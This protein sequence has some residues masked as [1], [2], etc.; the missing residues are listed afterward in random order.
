MRHINLLPWREERRRDQQKRFTRQT[1]LILGLC[2]MV[3]VVAMMQ[4]QAGIGVQKERNDYLQSQIRELEGRIGEVKALRDQRKLM[5]ERM[6][7]VLKLQDNRT[8]A[9]RIFDALARA[10]P[11]GVI[12]EKMELM[13]ENLELSGTALNNAE[14]SSFMR[15]LDQSEVFHAA[16]LDVIKVASGESRRSS[17][18]LKVQTGKAETGS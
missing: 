9:V 13:D 11:D 6:A 4:T 15:R 5:K 12:L 2:L 8:E 16:R 10:V 3:V 14:V 18:V 17:F 7:V 1:V